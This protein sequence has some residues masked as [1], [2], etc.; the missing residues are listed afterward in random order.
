MKII[1]I[2]LF[3]LLFTLPVLAGTYVDNF[4]DNDWGTWVTDPL[5]EKVEIVNGEVVI[6]DFDRSI[7][8]DL[9]FN[10]KQELTDF[11]VSFD[12]KAVRLL[13]HKSGGPYMWL[14]FRNFSDDKG[15]YIGPMESFE[16]DGNRIYTT[17]LV[18]M[19][20][21]FQL[22][23]T[24]LT[25]IPLKQDTWYHI[26]VEVQGSKV[27]I[28]VDDVLM[29]TV[30][31][32]NQP[33]FPQSGYLSIGGGGAELHFD[34]FSITGAEISLEVTPNSKLATMWGN[35]KKNSTNR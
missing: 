35:L 18:G 15:F 29:R 27:T 2:I 1:T 19:L 32:S 31:W 6:T 34:N 11:I 30:D 23:G 33:Q 17:I 22:V 28:W 8:S 26:K 21:A 4:D 12:G 5:S 7:S 9:Y 13:D 10:S 24:V 14:T 16:F 3:G 20:N 25:P